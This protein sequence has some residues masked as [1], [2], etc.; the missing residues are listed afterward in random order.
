MW[1]TC[2]ALNLEITF[3]YF[4]FFQKEQLS[5]YIGQFTVVV[6]DSFDF[7]IMALYSVVGG[8]T[9]MWRSHNNVSRPQVFNWFSVLHKVM[10]K[11]L[12]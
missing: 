1:P 10:S 12:A 11:C 9:K 2:I 5:K 6:Q 7:R 3:F 4:D 8:E